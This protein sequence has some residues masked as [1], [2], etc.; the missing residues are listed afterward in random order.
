MQSCQMQKAIRS[1]DTRTL[2][3]SEGEK[4]IKRP[5]VLAADRMAEQISGHSSFQAPAGDERATSLNVQMEMHAQA[6]S[7]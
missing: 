3:S 6:I 4:L 1:L 5:L 7:H 2:A